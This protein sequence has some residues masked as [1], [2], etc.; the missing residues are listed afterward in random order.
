MRRM[1]ALLL[2]AVA[3][4][5]G[6]CGATARELHGTADLSTAVLRPVIGA[7][8]D[9]TVVLA[10]S[11]TAADGLT[12]LDAV[13]N[14]LAP[15]DPLAA[16]SPLVATIARVS[17]TAPKADT[18]TTSFAGATPVD[19]LSPAAAPAFLSP[20]AISLIPAI[21]KAAAPAPAPVSANAALPGAWACGAGV[22]VCNGTASFAKAGGSSTF[23]VNVGE[24]EA[25]DMVVV[26]KPL[27]GH[28]ILCVPP[29]ALRPA[30]AICLGVLPCTQGQTGPSPKSSGQC[31]S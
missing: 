11:S 27:A 26:V 16:D 31:C 7:P 19:E 13:P 22:A 21:E 17:A 30:P 1:A 28:A 24:G 25:V 9:P 4:T 10:D 23:L 20:D 6:V 2:L 3:A 14:P 8:P 29:S 12:G 5:C 18:L 15:L